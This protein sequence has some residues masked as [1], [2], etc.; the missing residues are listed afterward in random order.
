MNCLSKVTTT[1]LFEIKKWDSEVFN[2][3]ELD[4]K[5]FSSVFGNTDWQRINN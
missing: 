3:G 4:K 1:D 2:S 5:S